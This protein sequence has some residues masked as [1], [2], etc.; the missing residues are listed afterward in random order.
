MTTSVVGREGEPWRFPV[1]WSKVWEFARA[2]HDDRAMDEPLPVPPTFPAYG[3]NAFETMYG[4]RAAGFDMRNVLHAE[5]EYVYERPIRVGDVLRCRTRVVDE[6]VKEG[7]RG[8]R[9]RFVVTETEM[10]DEETG[11]LVVTARTTMLQ[12]QAT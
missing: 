10:R 3:L 7:R 4:S 11:E 2:V 8:G 5:E 1:E 9:M 6:Y 12:K